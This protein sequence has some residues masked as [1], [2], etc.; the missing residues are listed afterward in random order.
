MTTSLF[1]TGASGFLGSRL[2]YQ[3][4][5][6][7]YSTITL[8][9]RQVA[10][11]PD[12]LADAGNV[13]IVQASL[14]ERDKYIGCLDATTQVVHLAAVTGKAPS[15]QYF[16]VNTLGTRVL[17][18][19]AKTAAVAGFLFVS[20]IAV[21]FKN[22][23]GYHYAE[24]KE[25]AEQLV[26]DSGL[27]YCIVRPTIILGNDSPTWKSLCGLVQG[28]F[29]LQLGDGAARIQPIHVDD[30]AGL[31]LT[32]LSSNRL[33]NETLELGGPE[34]ITIA[35]FLR[36]M[37]RLRRSGEPR[38]M[39]IPLSL[40]LP[41]LRALERF[42]PDLLPVSSGQFASFVNDGCACPNSLTHRDSHKMK[43]IDAMLADLT[44]NQGHRD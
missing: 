30:L 41:P 32:I 13:R 24:S 29:I 16:N 3:L 22:R 17:A 33:D 2:L 36:R 21:S 31:L 37:Y 4:K 42:F 18:D 12:H 19:A 38:V 8:L 44:G 1:I 5:P 28:P 10:A 9:Y 39:R 14:H 35:G 25:K 26:R 23:V 20:S 15:Q 6:E 7:K 27:S 34:A 43:D 11:L 40:I